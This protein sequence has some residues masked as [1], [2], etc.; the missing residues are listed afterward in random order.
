MQEHAAERAERMDCG[1]AF[2]THPHGGPGGAALPF[3]G[4]FSFHP[5]GGLGQAFLPLKGRGSLPGVASAKTGL[6][7]PI[8]AGP[9]EVAGSFAVQPLPPSGFAK[10]TPGQV[11]RKSGTAEADR[12][13]RLARITAR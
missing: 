4:A 3:R 13:Y 12:P 8:V 11:R 1:P 9:E 10:A 6:A 2:S 5:Y 7:A